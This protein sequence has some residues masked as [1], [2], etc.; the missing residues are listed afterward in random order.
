MNQY[1][2][3]DEI[4]DMIKSLVKGRYN[5]IDDE[6][7]N[8]LINILSKLPKEQSEKL[9]NGS[10]VYN[11]YIKANVNELTLNKIINTI[12]SVDQETLFNYET[13]IKGLKESGMDDTLIHAVAKQMYSS[14]YEYIR[15][16]NRSVFEL[17][18]DFLEQASKVSSTFSD[19]NKRLK[20]ELI[21]TIY[22]NCLSRM[23]TFW[24]KVEANDFTEVVDTLM[25]DME[26]GNFTESE[27]IELSKKCATIFCESS[28]AKIMGVEVVLGEYKDFCLELVENSVEMTPENIKKLKEFKTSQVFR[29]AGSIAKAN[30]RTLFH[31][32]EFLKGKSIGQI[33]VHKIG[34]DDRHAELYE[35]YKDV[36]I[37]L[38]V[39][40]LVWVLT[41]NP[42]L[43][44]NSVTSTLEFLDKVQ[45]SIISSY[46]KK[47]DNFDFNTLITRDNFLK[48]IP[49]NVDYENI[50]KNI[51][52]VLL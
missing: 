20:N 9:L 14:I 11:E 29:T 3:H 22:L 28:R 17:S 47:A 13:A 32:S 33:F 18:S 36:K 27:I 34:T 15:Q 24:Q 43:F 19:I 2:T 6:D 26:D 8:R 5:F 23:K 42:S 48:G 1:F 16:T 45:K 46:G 41:K 31:T 38:S 37:N 30:T 10:F 25:S 40:D 4:Q 44:T 39:N 12:L 52:N 50:S 49:K 21:N 51:D 7:L 35:K